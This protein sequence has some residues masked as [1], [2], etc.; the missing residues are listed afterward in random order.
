MEFHRG[1]SWR[2]VLQGKSSEKH[3][4]G[5]QRLLAPSSTDWAGTM[6]EEKVTIVGAR[7]FHAE[8]ELGVGFAGIPFSAYVQQK[9]LLD[10]M[11]WT[12]V[13]WTQAPGPCHPA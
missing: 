6:R 9:H 7:S 13:F 12:V 3:G 4:E 2:E 11:E 8:N 10:V 5:F 1:N